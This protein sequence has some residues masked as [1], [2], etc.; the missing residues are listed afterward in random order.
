MTEPDWPAERSSAKRT[1]SVRVILTD[2]YAGLSEENE[3]ELRKRK[4]HT[5]T[6]LFGGKTECPEFAPFGDVVRLEDL[7]G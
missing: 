2:G 1:R 5:L 4:L 3:Q 6:I 7:C